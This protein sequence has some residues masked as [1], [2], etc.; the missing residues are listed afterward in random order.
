MEEAFEKYLKLGAPAYVER[1]K[2]SIEETILLIKDIGGVPILAHP[3]LIKN[4]EILNYCLNKGIKGVEAIHPK[5]S[6][7]D[8]LYL[9]EFAKKNK[10][11]VTGGSD[12]HGDRNDD[13]ILLGQYYVGL[14]TI[15]Q[16]KEMI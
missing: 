3:G 6:K 11:L 7:E 8:V 2:I 12:F 1:Y 14:N 5:H 16:L 15:L 13:G 10:L 4:K 9:I